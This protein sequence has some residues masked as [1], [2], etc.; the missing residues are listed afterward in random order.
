M[1]GH[2]QITQEWWNTR[3]GDFELYI[4][5]FVLDEIALGDPLQAKKRINEVKGIPLLGITDEVS[6]L[7]DDL[8]KSGVIPKKAA[9]DSAHIALAAVHGMDFLLTWNCTHIA[10]AAIIRKI[11]KIC[12]E[13]RYTCPVIC[14]PEELL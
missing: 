2:Q 14:T 8:I 4:S 5:Q 3:S 7:A 6:I 11:E 12:Q 13:S 1:A 10:N 9:T